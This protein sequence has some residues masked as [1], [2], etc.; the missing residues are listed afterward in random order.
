MRWRIFPESRGE[1]PPSFRGARSASPESIS[2]RSLWS[3]GFRVRAKTRGAPRNDERKKQKPRPGGGDRT[4]PACPERH[5]RVP[6]NL[7]RVVALLDHLDDA[8]RA[9]FDQHGTAVHHGVAIR[10]HAER[11]RRPGREWR[12]SARVR[13]RRIHE[14]PAADRSRCRR[15]PRRSRRVRRERRRW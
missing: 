14:M 7:R 9:G 12:N 2:P 5:L 11:L 4:G 10:R 13:A 15:H 8:A 1:H 6:D 3:D